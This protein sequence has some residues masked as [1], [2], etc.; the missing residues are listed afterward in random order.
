MRAPG[1][2]QK[3]KGFE[4]VRIAEFRWKRDSQTTEYTN[5]HRILVIRRQY[6]WE[7]VIFFKILIFRRKASYILND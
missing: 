3:N 4:V 6:F 1:Y 5:S 7:I 2:R